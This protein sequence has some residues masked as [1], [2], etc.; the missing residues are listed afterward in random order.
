MSARGYTRDRYGNRYRLVRA[1]RQWRC[2]D[3][4][5]GCKGTG[6]VEPGEQ[7]L[8]HVSFPNDIHDGVWVAVECLPCA[9]YMQREGLTS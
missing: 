6:R 7:Y 1:R 2:D 5:W 3:A 4:A 9:R 8:R